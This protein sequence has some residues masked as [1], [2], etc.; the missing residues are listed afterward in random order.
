MII[1]SALTFQRRPGV[2]YRAT[3][4]PVEYWLSEM[5]TVDDDLEI[6][7]VAV[8]NKHHRRVEHWPHASH[9]HDVE[10]ARRLIRK[11]HDALLVLGETARVA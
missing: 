5:P 9:A 10:I 8:I 6:T 4:G 3:F 7:L 11:H 1:T 2:G